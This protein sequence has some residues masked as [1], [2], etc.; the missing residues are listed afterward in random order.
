MAM[1]NL[2][3]ANPMTREVERNGHFRFRAACR[4]VNRCSALSLTSV[5]LTTDVSHLI[6][7]IVW[8]LTEVK[9]HGH[10]TAPSRPPLW[11]EWCQ[12]SQPGWV[13]RWAGQP[14]RTARGRG[15]EKEWLQLLIHNLLNVDWS[16]NS[17]SKH[18]KENVTKMQ[19]KTISLS[20]VTN[21]MIIF[22]VIKTMNI[23]TNR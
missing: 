2:Y 23:S 16:F 4:Q 18:I 1:A 19:C 13:R 12:C 3:S 10:T 11:W 8:H 9:R 15:G 7:S 14:G 17:H 5:V 22:D 21:W 20:K 6:Q